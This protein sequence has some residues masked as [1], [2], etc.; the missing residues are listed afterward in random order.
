MTGSSLASI[1]LIFFGIAF[2]PL[3]FHQQAPAANTAPQHIRSPHEAGDPNSSCLKSN[4][5]QHT[6]LDLLANEFAAVSMEAL[7][8]NQ[9]DSESGTGEL[10]LKGPQSEAILSDSKGIAASEANCPNV[11]IEQ[12]QSIQDY[13]EK[14]TGKSGEAE[15]IEIDHSDE[16]MYHSTYLGDCG[17]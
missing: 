2:I 9:A 11:P 15:Q 13:G 17:C 7:Q 8:S 5:S 1:L 3:S 10:S 4:M 14:E 6:N 16:G 12:G